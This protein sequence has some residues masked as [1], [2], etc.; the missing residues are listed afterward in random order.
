[1]KLR[2]P[3]KTMPDQPIVEDNDLFDDARSWFSKF[4]RFAQLDPGKFPPT[5]YQLA[6]EYSRDKEYL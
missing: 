4:F 6:A 2:M 1:M 5:E 3:I